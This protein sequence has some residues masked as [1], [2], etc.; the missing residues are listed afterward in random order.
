M[1]L[2]ECDGWMCVA[3]LAFW[4]GREPLENFPPRKIDPTPTA[5]FGDRSSRE[6]ADFGGV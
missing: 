5:E 6:G 3:D 2:R 1:L 4:F